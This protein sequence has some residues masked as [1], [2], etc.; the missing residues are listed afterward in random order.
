[1]PLALDQAPLPQLRYLSDD[2]LK[3]K[4]NRKFIHYLQ[5]VQIMDTIFV[6]N[7]ITKIKK[8]LIQ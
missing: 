7:I 3:Y 8:G 5:Q 1:M 6:Q 4:S 2:G